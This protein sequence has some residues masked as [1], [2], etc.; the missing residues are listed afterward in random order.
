VQELLLLTFID[1]ISAY[2]SSNYKP[3]PVWDP[4]WKSMV[5]AVLGMLACFCAV[6]CCCKFGM[7]TCKNK[8][9]RFVAWISKN[10]TEDDGEIEEGKVWCFLCCKMLRQE[11]WSWEAHREECARVNYRKLNRLTPCNRAKCP[12]CGEIM[13]FCEV[14]GKW[15]SC[16]NNRKCKYQGRTKNDIALR[17]I[18]CFKCGVNLC[19]SCIISPENDSDIKDT[20]PSAP[21]KGAVDELDDPNEMLL[22]PPHDGNNPPSFEDAVTAKGYDLRSNK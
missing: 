18:S 20:V 14:D 19:G 7:A 16:V 5:G 12:V 17:R 10:P 15:F 13:K 6:W 9:P 1:C 22:P 3:D 21:E 2:G 8:C 11:K 4:L